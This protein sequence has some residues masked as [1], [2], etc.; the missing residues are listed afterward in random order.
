MINMFECSKT[1]NN[2][3]R[4][5]QH[6]FHVQISDNNTVMIDNDENSTITANDHCSIINDNDKKSDH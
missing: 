6:K 2:D 5:T 3:R 4:V 1:D